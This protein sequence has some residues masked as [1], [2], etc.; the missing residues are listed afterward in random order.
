MSEKRNRQEAVR[1][2]VSAAEAAVLK[3]AATSRC[4]PVATFIR[5][6]ALR[7][8][9][10]RQFR[11]DRKLTAVALRDFLAE[12]QGIAHQVLRRRELSPTDIERTI[13]ELR[14]LQLLVLRANRPESRN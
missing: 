11:G 5:E 9:D 6:A 14:R 3:A 10:P 1:C 13:S 12:L 7:A 4:Q 2:R 8:A